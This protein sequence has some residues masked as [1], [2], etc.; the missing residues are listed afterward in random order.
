MAGDAIHS[1]VGRLLIRKV[2]ERRPTSLHSCPYHVCARS[3]LTGLISFGHTQQQ[4]KLG[5]PYEEV[6][7]AR[8]SGRKPYIVDWQKVLASPCLLYLYKDLCTYV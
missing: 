4:M 6:K 5:I 2:A 7:I 3:A 8:T 1:L